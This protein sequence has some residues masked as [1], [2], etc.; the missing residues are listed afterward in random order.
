MQIISKLPI[1]YDIIVDKLF[2]KYRLYDSKTTIIKKYI[3]D[4]EDAELNIIIKKSWKS[5]LLNMNENAKII[6]AIAEYF[7][8]FMLVIYD[9]ISLWIINIQKSVFDNDFVFNYNNCSQECSHL[10]EDFGAPFDMK[11]K[12]GVFHYLLCVFKEVYDIE[13]KDEIGNIIQDNEDYKEI[14]MNTIKTDYI[15]DITIMQKNKIKPNKINKG[16]EYYDTLKSFLDT[17]DY[18]NDKFNSV[19]KLGFNTE[20]DE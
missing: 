8:N 2:N 14:I 10:W 18:K 15:D 13:F 17:K 11:A 1:N 4:I 9:I 12:N 6:E 3:P 19:K 7:D 20:E 16:R 5:I